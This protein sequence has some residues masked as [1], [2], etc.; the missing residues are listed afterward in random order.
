[1][2][3][4]ALDDS[5]LVFNE[6]TIGRVHAAES[7]ALTHLRQIAWFGFG[8]FCFRCECSEISH[9]HCLVV[10]GGHTVASEAFQ[11]DRVPVP[12]LYGLLRQAQGLWVM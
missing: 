5:T 1:M 4:R 2:P 10:R 8:F 6:E 12:V 7:D 9:R 3:P 11:Q